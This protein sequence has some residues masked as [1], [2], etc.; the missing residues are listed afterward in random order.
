MNDQ[1]RAAAFTAA[2]RVL[3]Q[4]FG[5]ELIPVAKIDNAGQYRGVSMELVPIAGWQ[6]PPAEQANPDGN[7]GE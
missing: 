4:R 1:Q 5:F 2:L 7:L 6:P 3:Q